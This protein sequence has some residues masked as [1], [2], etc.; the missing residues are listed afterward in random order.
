MVSKRVIGLPDSEISPQALYE[1]REAI[2]AKVQK[3]LRAELFADTVKAFPELVFSFQPVA[4]F[5][6][7]K[8]I[9]IA[10]GISDDAIL[11]KLERWAFVNSHTLESLL[12]LIGAEAGRRVG[13]ARLGDVSVEV[14]TVGK[15][16][17]D[18]ADLD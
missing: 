4:G 11:P 5:D 18:A 10:L 2:K 7:D 1:R 15:V 9:G 6:N 12:D 17:G 13:K 8:A 14:D 3:Q 16:V